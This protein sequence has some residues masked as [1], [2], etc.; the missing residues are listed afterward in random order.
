[1]D[2]DEL[3]LPEGT[4][5]VELPA[6]VVHGWACTGLTANGSEGEAHALVAVTMQFQIVP[7]KV[8]RQAFIMAKEDAKSL[9]KDLKSPQFVDN[10]QTELFN[11][12]E[13]DHTNE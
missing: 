10:N 2:S 3:E 6:A 9:R 13:S 1:M 5:V 12:D 8:G 7:G 4:E 11:T